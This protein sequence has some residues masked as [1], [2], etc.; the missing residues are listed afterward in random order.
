MRIFFAVFF[1]VFATS[2]SAQT[3]VGTT[4]PKGALEVTNA[5]VNPSSTGSASN[6]NIRIQGNNSNNVLDIGNMNSSTG[7]WIQ[8][9]DA[10]NYGTN[11]QLRINP[12]GGN[13]SIGTTTPGSSAIHV[14]GTVT[15]TQTI[16]SSAPGQLLNM[17]MLDETALGIS[18]NIQ[19][20]STTYTDI[21]SY[22]YTPVSNNSRILV[23][24]N[25]NHIIGGNSSGGNDEIAS[26]ITIN[27][28]AVQEK[29]QYF[30]AGNSGNGD[31]SVNLFPISAVYDNT[32]SSAIAIKVRMART[33][34]DDVTTV[35]PDMVLTITE[36]AD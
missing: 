2:I 3:G 6:G 30:P 11:S 35:Y 36:I 4:S 15:A 13:V 21:L 22:S 5:S 18:T 7:A 29:R 16:R 24:F 20:S 14:A 10:S 32:S 23:K 26:Q 8:S 17:V 31:R 1:A 28:T 9:R 33:A 27:G 19:N 12:K 25:V 34:G